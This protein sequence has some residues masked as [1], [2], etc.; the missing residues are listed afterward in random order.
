[1]S[2]TPAR[3]LNRQRLLFG[4]DDTPGIV[5][6][7]ATMQGQADV[8]RRVNDEVIHERVEF[9]NW[10]LVSDI[11][12]LEALS[13]ARMSFDEIRDAMPDPADGLAVV[14]LDGTHPLRYLVLTTRFDEVEAALSEA[15]GTSSRADLRSQALIRDATEQY[16]MLSGRT[17]YGGMAFSDVRRL[18][19]DLETTGL[20]NTTDTIFMISIRDSTGFE[21]LIDTGSM[22]EAEL[23]REFVRIVRERDPDVIENHNIFEFDIAFV[24]ERARV[25]GVELPLGRDRRGFSKSVDNLKLGERNERFTRYRLVGREII[26]TLHAAKRFSSIQRDLR[27]R[28]LKQVAQYFGF[29]REDREYV[30]GAEIWTIF[31]SDP[32]R[33]RRY[34]SH[35]VEEVDELSQMLMGSPFALA[36]I[37]PRPYERI[38]T[39]GPAQG[40]IEPLMIR[41]YLLEGHSLP[42]GAA[43]GGT[44]AGASTELFTSGVLHHIVKADVASLYP[45]I[46]L[47]YGIGPESDQLGA[48]GEI[49]AE[50]TKLR[51]FHKDQAR[52]AAPGSRERQAS[53]ALSGAMKVLIN[54]FYGSLGTSFALF[55]DLRA[56]SEVTR[57]GREVLAQMLQSLEKRGLTLIEADTDGVLFSVPESW[58]ESD[59][60]ALIAE[61]NTELP[62][63]II[64]EHDGR[65]AAMYSYAEKNYVLKGY[66]GKIKIVGGSFR[67]SRWEPYGERFVADAVAMVLND[68]IAGIRELYKST[69]EDLRARRLPIEDVCTMITVTKSPDE[70][71][72]AKRREEQYEV[73]LAAGHTTWRS[74]ERIRYY[75]AKGN[76]KK[77]I[78]DFADDYD[79]E[80][81]CKRLRSTFAARLSKAIDEDGLK[82]LLDDQG[83]LFGAD[84]G[85]VRLLTSIERTVGQF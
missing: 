65:Y 3:T 31:Q 75:R 26:D 30:P 80:Y 9:P 1:M 83:D 6:V 59:E 7:R 36:S 35:D 73:L 79:P 16:L 8:W 19:F 14:E 48:F 40:L 77:L 53:E 46:M 71:R 81:Y 57:R 67:S 76:A 13:P 2:N 20:S 84:L 85:E 29:A 15:N 78:E 28:G 22:D 70:Y 45:S 39:A 82:R 69:C 4:R 25:L 37:V 56:A 72:K 34:A 64:V 23:L 11:A 61:I 60:H 18:Q 51:L 43:A 42:Q 38:A 44:Y 17:Y 62:D 49:L 12:P 63:G 41:A 74:G 27:S 24:I 5:A 55:G 33:I 68:N 58:V 21:T 52:K 54:S 32:D 47:S 10:L 50:L 66:D